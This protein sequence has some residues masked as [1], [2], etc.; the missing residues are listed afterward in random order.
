L[1]VRHNRILDGRIRRYEALWLPLS[2]DD[3]TVT[4]LLCALIYEGPLGAHSATIRWRMTSSFGRRRW[5]A[6]G[7]VVSIGTAPVRR[8]SI[9][10][11]GPI[12]PLPNRW[13]KCG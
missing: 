3:C 11:D 9:G 5:N 4:M 1:A 10:N 13:R 12:R 6:I 8:A 2:D 7:N